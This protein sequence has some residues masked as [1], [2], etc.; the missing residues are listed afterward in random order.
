[1][2]KVSRGDNIVLL[3]YLNRPRISGVQWIVQSLVVSYLYSLTYNRDNL[4]QIVT[5]A[6]TGPLAGLTGLVSSP[7]YALKDKESSIANHWRLIYLTQVS[8][9][10]AAVK[11]STKAQ[12][13]EI[14]RKFK[15]S[16]PGAKERQDKYDL[17]AAKRR[18]QGTTIASDVTDVPL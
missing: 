17:M 14:I 10:I 1:M 6:T 7:F 9:G 18:S 8:E 2:K 4:F 16:K 3:H 5:K 12:Q 13:T 15:E 11:N